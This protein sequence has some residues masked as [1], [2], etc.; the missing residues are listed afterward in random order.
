MTTAA[1]DDL[2]RDRRQR[3]VSDR[4]RRARERRARNDADVAAE[5][6]APPI[7]D[8]HAPI[9]LSSTQRRL[10]FLQQLDPSSSAYHVPLV[11]DL[12]GPLD[13]GRLERAWRLV[14]TR[15]EIL[16]TRYRSVDGEPRANIDAEAAPQWHEL[17]GDPD[18]LTSRTIGRPFDLEAEQPWHVVLIA[19]DDSSSSSGSPR[20]RL[21]VVVHHIACDGWSASVLLDDLAT[22]YRTGELDPDGLQYADVARARGAGVG[23]GDPDVAY[24]VDH[25][26]GAPL[27]LEIPT[28]RPRPATADPAA[29]VAHVQLGRDAATA[30]RELA[31]DTATTPFMVVLA[32]LHV[33][34]G[35]WSGTADVVVGS[36][37]A[38]RS[39][40]ELA[41]IV[42]CFA[43][44]VAL[45]TTSAPD[46]TVDE[47]L[48]HVRDVVLSGLAHQSVPFEHVVDAVAPDRDVSTTPVY[49]VSLTVH[50]EPGVA[51]ELPGT[52][53]EWVHELP[54]QAKVDIALHIHGDLVAGVS[55]AADA[56]ATVTVAY[57]AALFDA[58]TVERLVGHVCQVL[59]EMRS[60]RQRPLGALGMLTE[61]E[62]AAL[63]AAVGAGIGIP[64]ARIALARSVGSAVRDVARQYPDRVAVTSRG[65][66]LTYRELVGAADRVAGALAATGVG[67]GDR[68]VL[69]AE[70]SCD[71]IVG[72]LATVTIGAAYVPVDPTYPDQRI[73]QIIAGSSARAVL[74]QGH[75]AGRLPGGDVPVVELTAR[76]AD[77]V[78]QQPD[79]PLDIAERGDVAYVLFTSGTTGAPKGV[80]VEHR[81]LL[82][83]LAG[84]GAM[85]DIDAGWSWALMTTPSADLGLTNVFGALTTG[86]RLHVL[87]YEQ[88]TDP[89]QVAGY[90]RRHAI[91]AMKLVP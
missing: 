2:D 79:A 58:A 29:A 63:P 7:R 38:D 22:A 14:V 71:V 54:P 65:V 77:A 12:N 57:R 53:A 51:L 3:L 52:S 37:V 21:V 26:A 45:R 69:L 28:D 20:H 89:E 48:E 13:G 9:E 34:L 42:G 72:M 5:P 35:R 46:H 32:A 91:D 8:P 19:A 85:V 1:P 11:N 6:P 55:D 67:R 17:T 76:P 31:G 78:P 43:N 66:D 61:R 86:G 60:D 73:A 70:R 56:D 90:F 82:A 36:P 47:L 81:H 30:V 59:A 44:T 33:V 83:Y 80:Q 15:H 24:W 27:T 68:V 74:S 4:L 49:Q 16:R 40:P 25:L 64:T 23:S 75:L 84:L 41:R 18:E 50:N 10:W 62:T 88:V 87:T 39:R